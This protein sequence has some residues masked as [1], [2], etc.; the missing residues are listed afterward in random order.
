M[1]IIN[2]KPAQVL[3]AFSEQEVR[4]KSEDCQG[5]KGPTFEKLSRVGSGM[6]SSF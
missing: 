5:G 1:N 2:L 3:P 4:L 6:E